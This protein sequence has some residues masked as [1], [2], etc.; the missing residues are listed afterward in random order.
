MGDDTI[1]FV[2]GFKSYDITRVV[3]RAE[4][5]YDWVE[6]GRKMMTRMSISQ[7]TMEWL[8]YT[9][10]EASKSHGYTVRRWK[11]QDHFTEL[12]C[13]RNYNQIGLNE[14]LAKS[15]VGSLPEEIP[16]ITLSEIRRWVAS[17]WRHNHGIN[18]F[19]LGRNRFLF[20]F[21]NRTVVDHI[22][23]G[24]W[25][26][27][28]Y[29]FSLQWWSPTSNAIF[30][31]PNQVWIRVVG[32]PLHLW[33]HKVFREI[34]NLCGGW[35]RTEEETE[36]RNHLKWARPKAEELVT[37]QGLSLREE[38]ILK[39]KRGAET[40][41]G[42]IVDTSEILWQQASTCIQGNNPQSTE[43]V[44]TS[45]TPFEEA[46]PL[47]QHSPEEGDDPKFDVPIWIHQNINKLAKEFGVDIKGCKDEALSLFMKIDG[48]RKI[49]K[50]NGENT[51]KA[52]P[53]I[54]GS[55]ELKSLECGSNGTR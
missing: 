53:I 48:M 35:I 41:M 40:A 3:S 29:K 2:V 44:S 39:E 32:L 26:W 33:S 18:I 11:R 46:V 23:R 15:V 4:T 17:T 13:A 30:E 24:D 36:L 9:L 28:S 1:F 20:E 42:N 21:P 34:G 47:N 38:E 51:S 8:A 12:F 52:T 6:R 22:V 55:K 50:D 7:K 54:K 5:W 49:N 27:K 45:L 10:K 37:A 43:V 19:D 16:G 14:S 31:R 25:F